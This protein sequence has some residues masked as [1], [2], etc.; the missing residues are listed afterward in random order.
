MK[1]NISIIFLIIII[2]SLSSCY[3]TKL[4]YSSVPE[5]KHI[6]INNVTIN[7]IAKPFATSGLGFLVGGTIGYL[8][9]VKDSATN[10][11]KIGNFAITTLFSTTTAC[12]AYLFSQEHKVIYLNNSNADKYLNKIQK[13]ESN[14]KKGIV[15]E[16]KIDNT[17]NG[18]FK[19]I[20]YDDAKKW[21]VETQ[22]DLDIY[23][24][25]LLKIVPAGELVARSKNVA[26]EEALK[27][28][29][30]NPMFIVYQK[31]L[32]SVILNNSISFDKLQ[33]NVKL[34]GENG[35]NI[36]NLAT[37]KIANSADAIKFNGLY[38]NSNNNLI[39]FEKGLKDIPRGEFKNYITN[40]IGL[41]NEVIETKKREFINQSEKTGDCVYAKQQ[42]PELYKLC[43]EKA[44]SLLNKDEDYNMYFDYFDT[45]SNMQLVTNKFVD[46]KTN[47][48]NQI[49]DNDEVEY[50]NFYKKIENSKDAQI[51][52]L[53]FKAATKY[54]SINNNRIPQFNEAVES[55]S[56]NTLVKIILKTKDG[57]PIVNK[58]GNLTIMMRNRRV[59]SHDLFTLFG[60][61]S[62]QGEN[63]FSRVN[64]PI[65]V[66]DKAVIIANWYREGTDKNGHFL[67]F[68]SGFDKFKD[69]FGGYAYNAG[70][71]VIYNEYLGTMADD[72][73][74][75]AE[76][77]AFEV[78][79]K[80]VQAEK[81]NQCSIDNSKTEY[82][83]D[84]KN[85]L[86]TSHHEG[87]IVMKNGD[88]FTWDY[89]DGKYKVSTGFMSEDSYDSWEEMLNDFLTKCEKKY[90][91]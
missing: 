40:Y 46:Y 81:C 74:K 84:S 91:N 85:W 39:V 57:S 1:K 42:F 68:N 61:K 82:P 23:I 9:P 90:C 78:R 25:Y 76:K 12:F 17:I 80:K 64:E 28:M 72:E 35:L 65:C 83:K 20:K 86:G 67:T 71:E 47:Q 66:Y 45:S 53:G 69:D 44:I 59:E 2:L 4:T 38:P 27:E 15:V 30:D 58:L 51:L 56:G 55:S 50:F 87:K 34:Y 31:E 62:S 21:V 3:S 48:Y 8:I 26:N 88:D 18:Y 37:E 60:L 52:L 77:R 7:K 41:G 43:D 10:T 54:E 63:N 29:A 70:V 75:E 19:I 13:K 49:S 5:K 32:I 33:E 79:Y 24:K 73:K 89:S 36:E 22:D 6:L 14:L 11:K 16:S